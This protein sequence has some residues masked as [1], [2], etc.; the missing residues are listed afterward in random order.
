MLSEPVFNS[1]LCSGSQIPS[2]RRLDLLHNWAR[3]LPRTA[4]KQQNQNN[5]RKKTL[6]HSYIIDRPGS[7]VHPLC[8]RQM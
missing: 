8:A 5:E 6:P 7:P 4:T 1:R 3:W 2:A